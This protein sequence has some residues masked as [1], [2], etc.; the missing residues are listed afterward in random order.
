MKKFVAFVLVLS[1]GLFCAVGC[2]PAAPKKDKEDGKAK[3]EKPVDDKKADEKK[4]DEKKADEKAPAEAAP[5][6]KEES[7]EPKAEK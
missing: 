5:A 2:K 3:V 1:L 6:A 4:V 7:T